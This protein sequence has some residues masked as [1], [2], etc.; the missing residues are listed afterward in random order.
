MTT[1]TAI[2]SYLD[3]LTT[4]RK[5]TLPHGSALG[6]V[7]LAV[8]RA[9]NAAID[10]LQDG[11]DPASPAEAALRGLVTAAL[12]SESS[13]TALAVIGYLSDYPLRVDITTEPSPEAHFGHQ[14]TAHLT[15]E[16]T[17]DLRHALYRAAVRAEDGRPADHDLTAAAKLL[18]K[19][20]D[21]AAARIAP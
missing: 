9:L 15:G 3:T 14:I 16:D 20:N 13:Q 17:D 4:M 8:Q 6:K 2:A 11:T 1:E 21:A 10:G 7:S 18:D 12:A 5:V 19:A